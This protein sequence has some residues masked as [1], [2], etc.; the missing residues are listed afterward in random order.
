[1]RVLGVNCTPKA[2]YLAT[3]ENGQVL[4]DGPQKV[5]LPDGLRTGP[6][7]EALYE[8]LR[9]RLPETG[10]TRA[11][12][13]EPQS[14]DSG[15]KATTARV[16]AETMLRWVGVEVGLT[17]ELLNRATARSRLSLPRGGKLNEVVAAFL[18]TPAGKYWAEG[19]RLA[20]FAA[21]ACERSVP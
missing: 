9:R 19:R 21:L 5:E 3:V 13:L 8:E 12:I 18:P 4:A 7:L 17:T 14:Y 10:A 1:M 16:A 11:A 15:L 20:A 6:A 2:I